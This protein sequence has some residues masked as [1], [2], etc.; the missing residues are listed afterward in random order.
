MVPDEASH[1]CRAPPYSDP[2]RGAPLRPDLQHFLN[3]SLMKILRFATA[4]LLASSASMLLAQTPVPAKGPAHRRPRPSRSSSMCIRLRIVLY[5]L[6]RVSLQDLLQQ[7]QYRRSAL[8]HARRYP[9]GHNLCSP[10]TV[11]GTTTSSAVPAGSTSTA[12]TSPQ[13]YPLSSPFRALAAG[14]ASILQILKTNPYDQIRPVLQ[15]V[16]SRSVFT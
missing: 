6:L 10:T 3:G 16:C 12:S 11:R 14:R 13:S 7:H 5:E 2:V 8:R 4:L 1:L 9:P 15:S